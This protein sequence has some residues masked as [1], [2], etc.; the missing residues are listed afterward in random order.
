MEDLHFLPYLRRGLI[1]HAAVAD[2]LTGAIGPAQAHL[3]LTVAG[4]LVSKAASLLAPHHVASLNPAEI[5]RREPSPESV[6]V[7][8]N[9]FPL[10]EFAAPDLPWR[11]SPAGPAMNGRLRPWLA[12][13]VVD[14]EEKRI[15]FF[16][17]QGGTARLAVDAAYLNQLPRISELW[18]WAHVQSSEP[19]G[20]VASAAKNDPA[21]LRSRIV[22]PRRLEPGKTYRACLVNAFAEGEDNVSIPAWDA[23]S[24]QSVSL[25][26]FDSWTFTTSKQHGDFE[27]LCELLEPATDAGEIGVRP[28][29]VST[30]GVDVNW[31]RDPTVIDFV[32]ALADVGV[33]TN[34]VP[35]GHDAFSAA[36]EPMLNET[37]SRGA[38]EPKPANYDPLRDDPVV[39]LPF[40]GAWPA[41]VTSVPQSGWARAVN[42]RTDRRIAA[43]LGAKTV[44]RNQEE[45]MAAAWDQLGS[46]REVSDELNRGRLSAEVGRSWLARVAVVDQ[47]DRVGVA[48]SLMPYLR[49]DGEPARKVASAGKAPVAILDR[50]WIRRTPRARAASASTAYLVATSPDATTRD[51]RA[52]DYQAIAQPVGISFVEAEIQTDI[53]AASVFSKGALDHALG[54]LVAER[55][56]GA[57][58]KDFLTG[59]IKIGRPPRRRPG[60]QRT[61]RAELAAALGIAEAVAAINPLLDT[62][63][64]LVSRIPALADLLP[65]G[66]L[67]AEFPL[68]PQFPDPL[69]WDLEKLDQ[70]VIVPG[71]GDFPNNRVR[72]LAVNAGFVGAYLVGANH[73]LA[74]EFLWREYPTDLSGTFF[75][76][77]FDYAD[78]QM[79]DIEPI[80]GWVPNSSLSDNLPNASASTVILIRGDLVRRYPDVNV[81]L[82]PQ[83]SGEPDYENAVQPSFEGRLTRDVLVVGFPVDPD[84][85]LGSPEYFVVLEERMTAPRFG[86]DIERRGPLTGWDELAWTDFASSG[87]HIGPGPIG[88]LGSPIF[89]GVEWGRNA[90]HLAAAVHQRPYR[91]LYPAGVLVKR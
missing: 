11:F 33:I 86:L 46:V 17:A 1:R 4:Q 60:R 16:A 75:Q 61:K 24:G 13:V 69:F 25:T 41:A 53:P 58:L 37:L 12:L 76:R 59:K 26:V 67:P 51:L 62:R 54:S 72:L 44:R 6:D 55:V 29:E 21:A 50:A 79:V 47:G 49:V 65:E 43:G 31:P 35:L 88:S 57:R 77:F 71:L 45:L 52:L 56:G 91:R 20:Q 87:E 18:A 84:V 23:A 48:A 3:E 64:S 74:R 40:Y 28:V 27:Y 15:E 22:C 10:I 5:L 42:L 89:D 7:E 66:E 78:Q 19:P 68:T 8:S 83:K 32:G 63:A 70:D 36:V 90:A 80:A 82:T 81:F 73:E 9:Y 38:D 34:R 39:G 14:A 30:A 85:V 2:P